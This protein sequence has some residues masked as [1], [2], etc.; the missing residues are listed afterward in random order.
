MKGKLNKG[1][2]LHKEYSLCAVVVY[3]NN[4]MYKIFN[5]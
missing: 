3:K 1:I 2:I 4:I 5:I